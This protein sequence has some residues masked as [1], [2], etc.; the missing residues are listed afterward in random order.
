MGAGG[1]AGSG[2]R[3]ETSDSRQSDGHMPVF[4][5]RAHAPRPTEPFARNLPFADAAREPRE[6]LP[7]LSAARGD[8]DDGALRPADPD[9]AARPGRGA[10]HAFMEAFPR[11]GAQSARPGAQPH[12][13]VAQAS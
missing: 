9:V 6:R 1:S 2:A 4:I 8:G 5:C 12:I 3:A 13:P 10:N 7:D 11:V